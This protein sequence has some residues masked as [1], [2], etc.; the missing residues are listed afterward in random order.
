MTLGGRWRRTV[1]RC[2]L[3]LLVV[4]ATAQTV[5]AQRQGPIAPLAPAVVAVID[6]QRLLRESEAALSIRAQVEARRDRYEAELGA[7]RERLE[8]AD[9][10]LNLQ[11]D[12]LDVEAYRER[13]RAFEADVATVQRLVQER[14][15]ELDQASGAAFQEIRDAVVTIIGELGDVYRFNVVLPRSDVLVFAPEVD[16]TEQV[17]AA[18]NRRLPEVPIP[19]FEE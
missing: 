16:L 2:A 6:Y 13:R 18:L 5:Q 12:R 11:R 4:G 10:A 17:M 1:A 19:A 8:A 3:A 7:E 15:R 9:R 14:R